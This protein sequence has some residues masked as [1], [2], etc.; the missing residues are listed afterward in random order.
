MNISNENN[1]IRINKLVMCCLYF[2]LLILNG[3][4]Y[5]DK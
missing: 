5:R 4:S 3:D 1:K 2:F